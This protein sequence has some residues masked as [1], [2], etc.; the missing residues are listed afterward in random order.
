[1][2]IF[3]RFCLFNLLA[4]SSTSLLALAKKNNNIQLGYKNN[5]SLDEVFIYSNQTLGSKLRVQNR[6]GSAYYMSFKE[7]QK[8]GYTDINRMLKSVPG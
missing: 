3:F 4:F 1:M 6:T 8:F 2:G 7:L 5:V